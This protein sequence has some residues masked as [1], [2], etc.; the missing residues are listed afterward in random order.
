M[1]EHIFHDS[2]IGEKIDTAVDNILHKKR[3]L[4][5]F[6]KKNTS[7]LDCVSTQQMG[8]AIRI[9]IGQLLKK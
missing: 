7:K 5:I 1:F 2:Y 6:P 4:D 3:T 8:E 9:E